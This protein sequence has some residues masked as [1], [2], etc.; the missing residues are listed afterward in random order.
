M[1]PVR[2][3][4]RVDLVSRVSDSLTKGGEAFK[5]LIGGLVPHE[6]PGVVVPVRDPGADRGDLLFDRAVRAAS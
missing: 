4:L 5:D 2:P 1:V 6:R 3:L